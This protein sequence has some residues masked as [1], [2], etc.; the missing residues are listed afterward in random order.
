VTASGL[1]KLVARHCR[2]KSCGVKGEVRT[3]RVRPEEYQNRPRVPGCQRRSGQ[4]VVH[5]EPGC[6]VTANHYGY[7]VPAAAS[8]L[9]LV[10]RCPPARGC[11]YTSTDILEVDDPVNRDAAAAYTRSSAVQFEDESATSQTRCKSRDR[12]AC[13][14]TGGG[15]L[16]PATSGSGSLSLSVIALDADALSTGNARTRQTFN[17]ERPVSW[18]PCHLC[19][20]QSLQEFYIVVLTQDSSPAGGTSRRSAGT[21]AGRTPPESRARRRHHRHV[22]T[23]DQCP[24]Y[25]AYSVRAD[26]RR[27]SP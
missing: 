7:H 1:G 17:S 20:K 22:L 4:K 25:F 9:C 3:F 23:S 15:R 26:P 14:H 18:G 6:F 5:I 21:A 11:V 10:G 16:P 27:S 12:G 13:Q 2:G 19:D 24:T 8:C